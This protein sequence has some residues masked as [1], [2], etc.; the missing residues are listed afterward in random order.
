M[1]YIVEVAP[2]RDATF[3]DESIETVNYEY[4]LELDANN[5]I[6][7]GKWIS[8]DYPDFIWKISKPVFTAEFKDIEKIY[9]ASLIENQLDSSRVTNE[10]EAIEMVYI[11]DKA[12]AKF[13][14][15]RKHYETILKAGFIGKKLNELKARR[16]ELLLDLEPDSHLVAHFKKR[17]ELRGIRKIISRFEA[18][19][20]K[21][22]REHS[23][24]LQKLRWL[25]EEEEYLLSFIE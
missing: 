3:S 25:K 18:L 12:L 24:T 20:I 8:E 17:N 7:G 4:Y 1:S 9:K 23:K 22:R 11:L 10:I 13:K 14:K 2:S 5:R 16:S 6:I 19:E 15:K 21:F